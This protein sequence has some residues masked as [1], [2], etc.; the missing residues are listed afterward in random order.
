MS[1]TLLAVLVVIGVIL[2]AGYFLLRFLVRFSYK[3]VPEISL[4]P[5]N[6]PKWCDEQKVSEWIAQFQKHGFEAAGHFECPEMP[7]LVLSGFVKPSE[8]LAGVIYDHRVAGTWADVYVQ[9]KDGGS[10]T[11]SNAPAGQQ[12]DHMPGQ[13]KTYG[14][15]S[16]LTELLDRTLMGRRA[17]GRITITAETFAANFEDA[18]RKE[19]KWRMERGGPTSQEVMRVAIEKGISLDGEKLHSKTQ[20]IQKIWLKEKNKPQKIK[21]RHHGLNLPDAFENP[22][23]FRRSMEQKSEPVPETNLPALPV[24]LVLVFALAGWTCYGFQYNEVHR[25]VSMAALIVFLAVFLGL[26]IILMWFRSYRKQVQLC[27]RLKKI[28]AIKAGTFLFISNAAPTLFYARERWIGKLVFQEGGENE[29]AVTRIESVLRDTGGWLSIGRKSTIG[30]LF[31]GS[32]QHRISLP[33]NDFGK[34]FTVSASAGEFVDKLIHTNIPADLGRLSA[35]KKAGVK[36]DGQAMRVEVRE[37][38]SGP[39]KE[40]RLLQFLEAAENIIETVVQRT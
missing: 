38:L 5:V 6:H 29:D 40:A 27:P 34:Q 8:Q 28:A 20:E 37:D 15:G 39:R 3:P 23:N 1:N 36:I 31:T 18:Y 9:Y 33:D 22:D 2:V 35:F 12:M 24:Y 25:P 30:D 10:L 17:S 14:R 4:V 16:S 11:V 32:D 21:S 26:F 13:E 19:M 7:S